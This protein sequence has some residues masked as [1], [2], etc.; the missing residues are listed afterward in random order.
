MSRDQSK[1]T[2]IWNY[3]PFS[4]LKCYL[5]S[6][7]LI[8]PHLTPFSPVLSF[9]FSLPPSLLPP[10]SLFLSPSLSSPLSL[11]GLLY[12]VGGFDGMAPLSSAECYDPRTNR[13]TALP[14]MTTKRFGLGACACEGN[15]MT[16][17]AWLVPTRAT[18]YHSRDATLCYRFDH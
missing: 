17:S 8:V 13:W 7:S 18:S 3:G 5:Y 2:S 16:T 15:H 10:L 4:M 12:A 1:Y 11:S 6:V 14:D 9:S